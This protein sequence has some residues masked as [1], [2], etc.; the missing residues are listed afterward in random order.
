MNNKMRKMSSLI[1]QLYNY[2][3]KKTNTIAFSML[4]TLLPTCDH[5]IFMDKTLCHSNKI[6]GN[7][8]NS[9]T[10]TTQ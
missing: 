2:S 4:C 3:I 1:I 6:N 10:L 5:L 8:Y 7:N 9:N